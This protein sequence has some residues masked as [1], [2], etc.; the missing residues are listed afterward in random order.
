MCGLTLPLRL[1]PS[2]EYK[3]LVDEALGMETIE[4]QRTALAALF[5]QY[6]YYFVS[7][8]QM[9]GAQYVT[10]RKT[11]NSGVCVWCRFT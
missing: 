11:T 7:G 1:E 6:G 3:A 8:V 9:G 2:T 5:A 10:V 4:E